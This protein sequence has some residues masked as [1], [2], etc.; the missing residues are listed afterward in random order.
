[1]GVA[2][3]AELFEFGLL[4]APMRKT[5]IRQY[6]KGMQLSSDGPRVPLVDR[7]SMVE[8][9]MFMIADC[10]GAVRLAKSCAPA[11]SLDEIQK[12]LHSLASKI[13]AVRRK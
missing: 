9:N 13:E 5:A 7:R 1:M 12:R 8:K 4:P 11:P 2:E 6:F 10:G 3:Q